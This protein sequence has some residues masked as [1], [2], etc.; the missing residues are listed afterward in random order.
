L[1][2]KYPH[3]GLLLGFVQQ[4]FR[5]L[6]TKVTI[7]SHP[8][9]SDQVSEMSQLSKQLLHKTQQLSTVLLGNHKF[10]GTAF[11]EGTKTAWKPKKEPRVE[12]KLVLLY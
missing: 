7:F 12:R 6:E 2:R 1:E 11:E 3:G 8:Q 4:L 5:L 10:N 9:H